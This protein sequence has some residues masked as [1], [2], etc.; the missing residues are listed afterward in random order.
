MEF[1]PTVNAT[2]LLQM[3][4]SVQVSFMRN[5]EVTAGEVSARIGFVVPVDAVIEG[6][7]LAVLLV[8]VLLCCACRAARRAKSAA[9]DHRNKMIET[10]PAADDSDGEEHEM[11]QHSHGRGAAPGDSDLDDDTCISRARAPACVK[12]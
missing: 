9:R 2:Q 8:V 7:A 11:E 12:G 4:E 6:A 3:G 10:A 1:V 5:V